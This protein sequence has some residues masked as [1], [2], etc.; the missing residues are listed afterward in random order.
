MFHTIRRP[1]S[2]HTLRRLISVPL[3]LVFL[4]TVM[5]V[6]I[7]ASNELPILHYTGT[8]DNE[9]N[10]YR[11]EITAEDAVLL[12]CT[13]DDRKK[14]FTVS[15]DGTEPI[16]AVC[17]LANQKAGP[18][19]LNVTATHKNGNQKKYTL[20][21]FFREDYTVNEDTAAPLVSISPEGT[22]PATSKIILTAT[23]AGQIKQISYKWSSQSEESI[24]NV[25]E[26]VKN[27]K[28]SLG[29][30][31]IPGKY[32]L[33]VSVQ[34]TADNLTSM[35]YRFTVE[36][37][38]TTAPQTFDFVLTGLLTTLFSLTGIVVFRKK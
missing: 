2:D 37:S 3:L 7:S 11:F 30:L 32:T 16:I 19:V 33:R 38:V 6:G 14:P 10:G 31:N 4:L 9:I 5:A 34:D 26:G 17:E 28:S 22:I 35:S 29:T 24:I 36:D 12:E 1:L 21:V 27:T 18:H 23:D 8:R 13:W 15:G 25:S 20:N